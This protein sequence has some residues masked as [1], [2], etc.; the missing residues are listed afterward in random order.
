MAGL[1]RIFKVNNKKNQLVTYFY[2]ALDE[3]CAT[4]LTEQQ[5]QAIESALT[6]ISLTHRSRFDCRKSYR[7]FGKAYYLVLLL[8]RDHRQQ[9]RSNEKLFTVFHLLMIFSAFLVLFTL[10]VLVLYLIK[11]AIGID[12]FPNYSFGIW[13]RFQDLFLLNS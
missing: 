8:G 2:Q 13:D 12:L 4:S 9:P 1:I 5:Q 11:S 10:A 7:L 3:S 6:I